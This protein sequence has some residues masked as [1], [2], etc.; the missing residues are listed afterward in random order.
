M[1]IYKCVCG[2]EFESPQSFNGHKSRCK[3]HMSKNGK[4]IC[5]SNF[6]LKAVKLENTSEICSYGCGKIANYQFS[7]GKFCCEAHSSK[8][9]FI[10]E[11]NRS[12]Q[13]GN[14]YKKGIHQDAWNKG[15]TKEID[16]RVAQSKLK[17]KRWGASLN[18][19]NRES[20]E[21]ISESMSKKMENRHIASKR[22]KH[23]GI[24]LESSWELE[25]AK[26]L[27]KN[28]ILYIRPDPII[29]IDD[30]SQKHRYYPDF[31]LPE[32]DLYLDPKNDY[33]K[34]LDK[35]KLELVLEQNE[36][37]LLILGKDELNW[38]YILYKLMV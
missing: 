22:F 32:F 38:N 11:K 17:G 27:D 18:G 12:K 15:L 4:A 20:K 35:R 5:N 28:D 19:H 10:K 3:I 36:I 25:L 9:S 34:V 6:I 16:F 24:N 21:K 2:R 14:K 37:K 30:N 1:K 7:N 8:C 13:I 31:Y 26:D 33:V 23:N 29:W